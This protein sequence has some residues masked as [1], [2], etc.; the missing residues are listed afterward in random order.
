MGAQAVHLGGLAQP[1][2]QPVGGETSDGVEIA[3]P[4]AY[5]AARADDVDEDGSSAW[6][7]QRADVLEDGVQILDVMQGEGAEH[8]LER[9]MREQVARRGHAVAREQFHWPNHAKDFVRQLEEWAR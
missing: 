1:S 7:H 2:V 6:G 4:S 9:A 8:H 5:T 3:P